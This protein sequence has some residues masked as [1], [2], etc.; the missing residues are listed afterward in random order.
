MVSSW[1]LLAMEGMGC[2]GFWVCAVR[3]Q[4]SLEELIERNQRL[5]GFCPKDLK[6]WLTMKN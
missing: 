6:R 5:K 3:S 4:M 2:V 1:T